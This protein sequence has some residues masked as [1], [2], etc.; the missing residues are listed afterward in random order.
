MQQLVVLGKLPA[1]GQD[2]PGGAELYW[3]SARPDPGR[4]VGKLLYG[5]LKGAKCSVSQ[6]LEWGICP[7][8]PPS[9]PQCFPYQST[10][11]PPRSDPRG[12]QPCR[13]CREA[14]T[15]CASTPAWVPWRPSEDIQSPQDAPGPAE[16]VVGLGWH[17]PFPAGYLPEA[18]ACWDCSLCKQLA[19]CS[20]SASTPK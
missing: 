16:P 11:D 1:A 9:M 5:S 2:Q 20:L 17:L 3:A 19:G 10:G 6:R 13:L 15:G 12:S 8:V 14:G 7:S 18:P 4:C